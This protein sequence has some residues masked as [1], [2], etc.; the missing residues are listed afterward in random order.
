MCRCS[1][2]NRVY[3]EYTFKNRMQGSL[4]GRVG[5]AI[6]EHN[7]ILL[8]FLTTGVSVANLGL[9]YHNE[10][11]DH[12]SKNSTQ[13]GWLVG[14][15]LEWAFAKDWSLRAD[16]FYADYGNAVHL[17]LPTIYGLYDPN[18]KATAHLY[19]NYISIALNYWM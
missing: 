1:F 2:N 12:Y 18:G 19:A 17:S 16:Y 8:P 9:D 4:R 14:A 5:Y 7:F 13:A 11:G 10:A 15:G 3:D 6:N